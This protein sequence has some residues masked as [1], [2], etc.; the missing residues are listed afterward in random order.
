VSLISTFPTE[1]ALLP[2]FGNF[3]VKSNKN[4]QK[5]KRLLQMCFRASKGE[6]G[7]SRGAIGLIFHRRVNLV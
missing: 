3:E 6:T 7:P 4:G 2:L 1:K 5:G